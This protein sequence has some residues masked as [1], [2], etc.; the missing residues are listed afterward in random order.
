M[1]CPSFENL[2]DYFDNAIEE[3]DRTRVAAHLATGCLT[4]ADSLTW[5]ERVRLVASSDD[6]IRPPEWVSKR[7]VRVFDSV[8]R[9]RIAER[10]GKLV[11][12]L[13]FDSFGSPALAGVRSSETVNRQLLYRAGNYSIDLQIAPVE[14]KRA[15]LVGQVLKEGEA[16]FESVSGLNLVIERGK[17]SCRF[18]V[19]TLRTLSDHFEDSARIRV[20]DEETR[21]D[22][23]FESRTGKGSQDPPTGK[24][25]RHIDER[26]GPRHRERAFIGKA[27]LGLV[28]CPGRRV[29]PKSQEPEAER[30]K[31]LHGFQSLHLVPRPTGTLSSGPPGIRRTFE[32]RG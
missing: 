8:Q 2:I 12:S 29:P 5:Y 11:A 13:V 6:S 19:V 28:L 23:A 24:N 17:E 15:D 1:R 25:L 10:I 9:P 18:R 14:R 30:A 21:S 20:L 22:P 32:A 26:V 16:N 3:P 27:L 7:A 4:C 31:D